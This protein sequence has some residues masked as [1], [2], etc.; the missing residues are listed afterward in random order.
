MI[1]LEARLVCFMGDLE[2]DGKKTN[3]GISLLKVPI[4]CD[5][6]MQGIGSHIDFFKNLFARVFPLTDYRGILQRDV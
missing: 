6:G 1:L 2:T 3:A 5:N 4:F